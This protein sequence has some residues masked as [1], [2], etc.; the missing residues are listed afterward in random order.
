M[1]ITNLV[2]FFVAIIVSACSNKQMYEAIQYNHKIECQKLPDVDY[3]ACINRHNSSYEEY[4][5]KRQ[6]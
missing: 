2:V 6:Q 5:R 4:T 3:Q 1:R